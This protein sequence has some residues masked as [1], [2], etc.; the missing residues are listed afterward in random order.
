MRLLTIILL[1]L[2]LSGCFLTTGFVVLAQEMQGP[3]DMQAPDPLPQPKPRKRSYG[4]V[5]YVTK[6]MMCNDTDVVENYL[7]HTWGQ[8]SSSFGLHRNEMGAYQ[9]LTAVY[10][11]PQTLTFSVVE[12]QTQGLSCI[13]STGEYWT[14]QQPDIQF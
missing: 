2:T 4:E 11:N 8:V 14:S 9:M 10:V 1:V 13:V 6:S 12:Q 7:L 3:P 5:F